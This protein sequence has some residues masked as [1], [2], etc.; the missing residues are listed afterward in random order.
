MDKIYFFSADKPVT[1]SNKKLVKQAII[2]LFH[3]ENT[4]L[5]RLNYIFCSDQYLLEMNKEYLNHNTLTDVITFTLSGKSEP[6]DGEVYLSTDRI[7]ENAKTY[8]VSYENEVL[9]VMFHGAL[10]LCGYTD[11]TKASKAS[12]R[13]KEDHYLNQFN[14][15]REA[16]H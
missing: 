13:R 15:S 7:K 3:N 6:I 16:N 11:K 14:V 12:M 5:L 8:N 4:S 1:L 2:S 9:R 10:H